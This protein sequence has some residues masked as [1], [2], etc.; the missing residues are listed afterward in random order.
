MDNNKRKR[1]EDGGK[2]TTKLVTCIRCGL[3]EKIKIIDYDRIFM[4]NG[5]YN[6][7]IACHMNWADDHDYLEDD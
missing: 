3:K 7:H 6:V 1:T 4:K 2:K 5:I